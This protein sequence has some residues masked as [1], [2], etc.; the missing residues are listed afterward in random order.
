MKKQNWLTVLALLLAA[1]PVVYL[2]VIYSSLPA[3][4]PMHYNVHGAVDRYGSP[5]ELLAMI[6]FITGISVGIYFLLRY[7]PVIDPKRKA[8]PGESN[9]NKMAL[10][11]VL[12]MAGLSTLIIYADLHPGLK[13]EKLTMPVVALLF[14]FLG[15]VMYNI[16]PNYFAG[17]RTPWTLEDEDT[18]RATHRM[19]GKL[20]FAAGLLLAIATLVLP[21]AI[22]ATV[23]TCTVLAIV[24]IPAVYS[25]VYFKKHHPEKA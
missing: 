4:V 23:F 15:N 3:R 17:L 18:W 6:L 16:K 11:I 22:A 2:L 25:Y 1:A 20:W 21:A 24:L 9:F 12:F 14:A 8:Q 7:L 13:M 5:S 10:G 19:G